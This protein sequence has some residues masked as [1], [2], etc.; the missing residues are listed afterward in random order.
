MKKADVMLTFL[1]YT[2]LALVIFIPTCMWAS[3]FLKIGSTRAADSYNQLVQLVSGIGEREISSMPLYMNDNSIIFGV[4]KN[5]TRVETLTYDPISGTRII[6]GYVERPIKCEKDKACLC[7]CKKDVAAEGNQIKCNGGIQCSTFDKIDFLKT[8]IINDLTL[9]KTAID[10]SYAL[11]ENGFIL[12]N[13]RNRE[14]LLKAYSFV[15]RENLVGQTP[16]I[17]SNSQKQRTIYVQRYQNFIGVCFS[18]TCITDETIDLLNKEKAIEEFDK[19]RKTHL[20]C[21]N[22]KDEPCG[23]VSLEIPQ[24]YFIFYVPSVPSTSFTLPFGFTIELF[25]GSEG[26]FWLFNTPDSSPDYL[27]KH[28]KEVIVR[29]KNNNEVSFEGNI[30]IEDGNVEYQRGFFTHFVSFEMKV[31]DGKVIIEYPLYSE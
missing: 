3:Q 7:L 13:S 5:S 22:K 30:Y 4:S 11:W 8:R 31:K 29:D 6:N 25:K 23:T 17:N 1:F 21:K 19:F 12:A 2:I 27:R 10:K 16:E 9:E 15:P 24:R 26:K 28:S 18:R 14:V 20:E